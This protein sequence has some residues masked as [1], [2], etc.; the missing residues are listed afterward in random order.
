MSFDTLVQDITQQLLLDLKAHRHL[1]RAWERMDPLARAQ[2][3]ETWGFII[4][5]CLR[6]DAQLL[7]SHYLSQGLTP[8]E[9]RSAVGQELRKELR[10]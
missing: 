3:A 5:N 10:E 4:E 7:V 1:R 6:E 9:A 2:I 8:Q